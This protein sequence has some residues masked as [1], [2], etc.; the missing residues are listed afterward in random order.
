M[1]KFRLGSQ[2]SIIVDYA[3][4]PDAYTQLFSTIKSITER[5]IKLITVFG[6]GGNRDKGKRSIMGH[7]ASKYSK[8]IF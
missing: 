7:I 8:K 1:E 6:C 3:H 5:N 2:G 4:S